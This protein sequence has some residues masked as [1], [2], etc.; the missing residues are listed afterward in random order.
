VDAGQSQKDSRDQSLTGWRKACIL[1]LAV[2]WWWLVDSVDLRSGRGRGKGRVGD[3]LDSLHYRFSPKGLRVRLMALRLT[4]GG[5]VLTDHGTLNGKRRQPK[6]AQPN[7]NFEIL[8][9][10]RQIL[11]RP[12][13]KV[14]YDP[15]LLP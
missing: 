2:G 1:L 4:A 5:E 15:Y 12:P 11:G 9:P 7:N 10:H 14:K 8:S 13:Y 6:S 3:I